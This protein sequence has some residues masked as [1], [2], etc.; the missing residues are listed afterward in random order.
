MFCRVLDPLLF[1]LLDPLIRRV[2]AVTKVGGRELQS[3]YYERPHDQRYTNHV[4]DMLLSITRFGGQ[5][6]AKTARSTPIN[7]SFHPGLIQRVQ[8]GT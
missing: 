3:Y 4:L 6:F 2:P 5:G 8:S 1:D 7:K